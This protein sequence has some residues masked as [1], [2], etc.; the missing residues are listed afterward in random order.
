VTVLALG[1]V[2][3][4]PG[5]TTAALALAAVWPLAHRRLLLVEADPGGGVL[6]A[7]FRMPVEGA[8]LAS[9][10]A[11]GR[12]TLDEGLLWRHAQSLPGGL[13][14]LLGPRS[15]DVASAALAHLAGRLGALLPTL[16]DT[17]ALVDCGRALPGSPA[18]ELLAAAD[19]AVLVARPRLEE[20][21]LLIS[22]LEVLARSRDRLGV[23]ICGRGPYPPEQVQDVLDRRGSGARVLGS[24]PYDEP[25]AGALSDG[26]GGERILRRSR[27]I[28]EARTVARTIGEVLVPSP[29]AEEVPVP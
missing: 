26:R 15:A 10:A 19:L 11:A 5:V 14:V 29:V 22:R 2:A 9:L 6:A 28:V 25:G 21:Q 17:D 1:S 8:G 3:G 12:R 7:R 20:L 16:T 27:L 24:L 4:A 23:L 13:E 18:L